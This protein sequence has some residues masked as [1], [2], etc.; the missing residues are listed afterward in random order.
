MSAAYE[1][2]VELVHY[3]ECITCGVPI[4]G[5]EVRRKQLKREHGSFY[6]INGHS[7]YW[8]SESDEEKLRRE[9]DNAIKRKDWAEEAAK[10][11]RH[12]EA[13][14]RGKLK[15]QTERVKNGVCPCCKR[16]FQ[17]LRRHMASKHPHWTE[18]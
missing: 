17:N 6:C 8:P 18:E 5:P 7:Q 3:C 16:S 2:S 1:I 12:A 9:R 13:I 4:F 14:V 11:A 15:A 10:K